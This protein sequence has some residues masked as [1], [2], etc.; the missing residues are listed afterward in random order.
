MSTPSAQV[1]RAAGSQPGSE[2]EQLQAKVA[3]LSSLIEVSIIVNSTLDLDNVL[4][5]VMEKAQAVMQAEASSVML[6]NEA[7][8]MLEWEVALGEVG[9][10]VKDKIHLR[11]GEGIAGWVAQTGEPLIVPDVS[12]DARFS[13]KSDEVTGFRTRSILAAPLKVRNRIIGVAEVINPV[14]GRNFSNDDLDLFS[15]F[16]RQVALAIEN[17]RNH[18]AMLEKQKLDQQ[19]EA[20]RTIQESFLPQKFPTDA[21]N[22]FSVAARSVPAIQIGGDFYDFVNCSEDALGVVMGDVS[23]KGMPAA[24]YMAHLMSDFRIYSQSEA[25]PAGVLETINRILVERGRRGMFVTLQYILLD[26]NSGRVDYATGGHLPFLWLRQ[27]GRKSEFVGKG[28]GAPLGILA[29]SRFVQKSL[30]LAA[31]DYL[32]IFTDGVVEA[33][34]R[35]AK[36][37]SMERL[38]TTLK[39]PWPSPQALVEHLMQDV[40]H[41]TEGTAQHDDQT[42]VALRWG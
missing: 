2:L 22:R 38:R 14:G 12:R 37:Y 4:S 30:Q 3:N 21:R 7:T 19:L 18:R 20:A 16:C 23:G 42:V 29:E 33:K 9:D 40:Q 26:L 36:Q 41:F 25:H 1:A 27:H 34:N 28:G 11:V 31:G 32:I 8:N 24:L 13:K 10:Q 6:I 39:R 35:D 15:T 17:A 5:L